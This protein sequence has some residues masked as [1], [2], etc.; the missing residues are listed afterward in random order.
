VAEKEKLVPRLRG[1]YPWFDHALRANDAFSERDGNHYA[2]AITYFSVLSLFPLLMVGFSVAGFLLANNETALNELSN[3]ILRAAPPGLGD[4]FGSLVNAALSARGTTGILG[5]LLA[6]YSGLGWMTNL[7][8]ALTAQWGQQRG[9]QPLISTTLKDLA[10]LAGLGLGLIMPTA[11]GVALGALSSE[12]SGAGSA[13]LTAMRQ[14]GSTIGVAVLG[15]LI[16]NSYSHGV[17]AAA[18]KLPPEVGAAVRSSV[19]AGVAVAEKLGSAELLDTVRSSF[20][21][22]MDIMLWTCGGIAVGC[23]VLAAVV[24]RPGRAPSAAEG[25]AGAEPGVGEGAEDGSLPVH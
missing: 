16:S 5:L 8:D 12:R 19:A 10:A 22:G 2:A 14:V 13:L 24:L 9:K 18:D 17:A 6:L 25:G 23:A 15:T 20:V 3:A 4:L 11:M 7:R 21:H 1:K